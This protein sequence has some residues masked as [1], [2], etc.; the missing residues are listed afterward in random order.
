MQIAYQAAV[1]DQSQT[2]QLQE[3][4]QQKCG[5]VEELG[6]QLRGEAVRI[7]ELQKKA[8]DSTIAKESALQAER[9]AQA[10]LT[11][12]TLE[13]TEQN[14]ATQQELATAQ[15]ALQQRSAELAAQKLAHVELQRQLEQAQ[16]QLT[17]QQGRLS[18]VRC[19]YCYTTM[20]CC[21]VD[22]TV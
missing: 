8:Y 15:A 20:V 18:Q 10:A 16:G 6:Q 22:M 17:E 19:I 7:L 3:Q 21:I 9:A 2:A 1:T 11:S 5:Q 14:K 13:L 12:V 4:L